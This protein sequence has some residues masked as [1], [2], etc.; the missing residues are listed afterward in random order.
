MEWDLLKVTQ[1]WVNFTPFR[2]RVLLFLQIDPLF[3]P[4]GEIIFYSVVIK[5]DPQSTEKAM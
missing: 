5:H 2:V 3:T 1:L 4:Y